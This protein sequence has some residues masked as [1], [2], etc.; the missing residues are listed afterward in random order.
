MYALCIHADINPLARDLTGQDWDT[1]L[2]PGLGKGEPDAAPSYWAGVRRGREASGQGST[3]SQT[4]PF[5]S[6]A[7]G[8]ARQ[9]PAAPRTRSQRPRKGCCRPGASPFPSAAGGREEA[10]RGATRRRGGVSPAPLPQGQGVSSLEGGERNAAS[11]L[12]AGVRG[13][14]K[15]TY[16]P[17]LPTRRAAARSPT[18]SVPQRR[19]EESASSLPPAAAVGPGRA[20]PLGSAALGAPQGFRRPR[21]PSGGAAGRR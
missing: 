3:A 8:A 21:G 11:Q 9:R 17:H 16:K 19:R 10:E 18:Q 7:P 5:P 20:G 4:R 12:Q 6:G 15:A 1:S 2:K 13:A 14:R